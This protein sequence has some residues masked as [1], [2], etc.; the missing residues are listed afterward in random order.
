MKKKN[1]IFILGFKRFGWL[2][3]INDIFFNVVLR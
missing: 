2:E 1:E 3:R